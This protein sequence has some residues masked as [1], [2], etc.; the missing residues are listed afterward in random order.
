MTIDRRNEENSR[1]KWR[2]REETKLIWEINDD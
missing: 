1:T 2:L